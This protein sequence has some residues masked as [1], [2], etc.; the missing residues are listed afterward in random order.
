MLAQVATAARASGGGMGYG[1]SVG[2]GAGVSG[3]GPG[4]TPEI[5]MAIIQATRAQSRTPGDTTGMLCY[6]CG[7]T[8]HRSNECSNPKNL[9]LVTQVLTAQG[10][11]PCEHC[12][13]F[14]HPPHLC[15]NLPSNTATRPE[16]WRGPMGAKP[17]EAPK[18]YETGNVSVDHHGV[19]SHCELSMVI[20]HLNSEDMQSVDALLRTM[21]LSIDDPNVWIGDTG[22]T[23]HNTAYIECSTNHRNATAADHIVGVTG[24]PAEAKSII[25]IHCQVVNDGVIKYIKLKD[26]AYVPN[27][28]YN[29]FSLTKQMT[30]GWII[31][32]D[33]EVGIVMSKGGVKLHFDKTVHT[34]KGVLYVAVLKRRKAKDEVL[35]EGTKEQSIVED[36]CEKYESGA[37]QGVE[38]GGVALTVKPITINT[39][40]AMCGH[41]G[42]VETKEICD[43]YG[44][45]ITKR[46]F[47]QCVR[48]GKAKAK[49]LTV[50][51]N[52]EEHIVAGPDKHRIF[53][54]TSSVKHGSGKKTLMS[55]PYWL[56]IVVEFVNYKVSI[57]LKRKSDLPET[58]CEMVHQLQTAGVNIKYVRL[59]NAGENMVFA[60]LA[61]SKQWNLRLVF[62]FTGAG[63]PQRNYLVELPGRGGLQHA[64]GPIA[65]DVRCSI[66]T[67]RAEVFV[68]ARRRAPL[69]LPGRVDCLRA[70]RR[71]VNEAGWIYGKDP[72]VEF[73]IR[74][75]GEAGIVKVIGNMKSK[76]EMRGDAGMFVGYA[77]NSSPDTYRMYLP[78][79]NSIHVTR[80]VQ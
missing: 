58:A 52:K 66:S 9:A 18:Q 29:L 8:G 71:K 43:H 31:G 12:G 1:G 76:L 23:T 54:D 78:A 14:G 6:S 30:S 20:G 7:Q 79:R 25:D 42:H 48:C 3:G 28:R 15:W 68:S 33:R 74:V 53:I 17:A 65:G 75:W 47:R 16:Y 60:K 5:M 59:D 55:K 50:Q 32:G 80:D 51:Q 41:M 38:Y 39:A 2:V 64:V 37:S 67:Q 36:Q 77:A 10:R 34:P 70:K 4:I 46:G 72:K 61:N 73:P 21:G 45:P 57:F 69:D 27:S 49:Q 35:N 22:A 19:D 40:H 56:L 11:K 62:E 44:Q 26:V 24:P 63:T 13:K